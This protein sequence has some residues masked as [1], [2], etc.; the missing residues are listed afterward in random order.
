[1]S[2]LSLRYM[3]QF[4]AKFFNIHSEKYSTCVGICQV[5]SCRLITFPSNR[6][7]VILRDL[8]MACQIGPGARYRRSLLCLIQP[9]STLRAY[10]M[11]SLIS[12]HHIFRWFIALRA[13]LNLYPRHS[14]T[15]PQ[16]CLSQCILRCAM[17]LKSGQNSS[18]SIGGVC[19]AASGFVIVSQC[20]V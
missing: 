16:V 8:V 7:H 14:L 19:L 13:V 3:P 5:L 11:S 12:E 1:M 20:G 9:C 15:I 4:T 2:Q 18:L 10:Q 17:M 6:I